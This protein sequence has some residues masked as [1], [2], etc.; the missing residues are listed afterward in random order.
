MKTITHNNLPEAVAALFTRIDEL[1]ERLMKREAVEFTRPVTQ[2][3]LC[4]HYR[5]SPPT[6]I[7]WEKK[8]LIPSEGIGKAKRYDLKKVQQ[9]LEE[10]NLI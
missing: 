1:E 9:A 10:N 2:R 5:I 4:R 8:G 6:V 7:K 3:E